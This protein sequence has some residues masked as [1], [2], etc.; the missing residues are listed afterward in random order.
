METSSDQ[1][2][3]PTDADLADSAFHEGELVGAAGSPPNPITEETDDLSVKLRAV[4]SP[5]WSWAS[6][7]SRIP[8]IYDLIVDSS[9]SLPNCRIT[10]T[11]TDADLE[12]GK[13]TVLDGQLDEGRTLIERVH[14]PLSARRMSQITERHPAMCSITVEDK[15]SGRILASHEESVDIQPRDLW[16]RHGDPFLAQAQQRASNLIESLTETDPQSSEATQIDQEIQSLQRVAGLSSRLSKSLL[17]SFVRPNHPVVAAV[18]R[19]AADLLAQST[20]DAS[21]DAYQRTPTG[22]AA[23]RAD[24][25]VSAIYR[26]LQSRS[27]VYSEPPP[28]WDYS[29]AGQRIRDHGDV[30]GGGEGTCL[31]TTVLMAAVIEQVG[32][33]P[34]LL[35]MQGHIFV[36]YWRQEPTLGNHGQSPDWYP[37][38]P[39]VPD[40][41]LV[42]DLVR[43]GF[44]GVIETTAF[45]ATKN[46]SPNDARTLAM[47]ALLKA[48]ADDDDWLELI[49][50]RAARLAGVSPL[51]AVSERP[52]GVVEIV[53]YRPGG[54]SEVTEVSREEVET[55]RRRKV[56]DHPVRYRTWKSSLF[57][58]NANNSLLNL[59]SS[60]RVQPLVLPGGDL[61]LLED[62]L[63]QDHSFQLHSGFD[64]SEVWQA[65]GFTN[66]ALLLESESSED[67]AELTDKLL[68]KNLFVQRI[69]RTRGQLAAMNYSTCL[70]ELKSMSHTAKVAREERGMNPLFLCLGLLQWSYKS[71]G[72]DKVAE[73][74]L[75][76]VPVNLTVTRR[77]SIT[78]SLDA[79]QQT[80]TNAA[81]IEWL[82][83]EHGIELE[84][85]NEP[86][87]D[88][89]GLDVDALLAAVDEAVKVH[90]LRAQI[91]AEAKLAILDLSAFRMWQDMNLHAEQ[92]LEQPL[93][94]HL[95]HTPTEQ[96]VDPALN[97]DS[98]VGTN[99]TPSSSQP[100]TGELETLETPLPADATQKQAVLWAREGRTFVLQGPP[101]T[102]K[103]Q[104][105][106]NIVSECVLSGMRVLFVAEKGTALSVVQDRLN[107]IGLKPFTLNLHHEGSSA[108]EVRAQL[109]ASMN[110]SVS[111]DPAAIDN[112]RR[113]LRNAR[114]YLGHYPKTLHERNAA[115]LSAYSARDRLLILEDGPTVEVATTLVAHRPELIE[116]LREL[117][118]DLQRWTTAAQVRPDHPWRLAGGGNADPFD[119]A[120]V[121][122]AIDDVIAGARWATDISGP[123]RDALESIWHPRQLG[124]LVAGA[125]PALPDGE[126]L[127]GILSSQW[128]STAR[129]TIDG[130]S[131]S[132]EAW[133]NHLG[134]FPPEVLELDLDTIASELQ[135]ASNSGFLGRKKRIAAALAPLTALSPSSA[136]TDPDT[137]SATLTRLREVQGTARGI[138]TSLGGVP[139]FGD[140]PPTNPFVDGALDPYRARYDTLKTASEPLRG[141][142][143]WMRTVRDLAVA[144]ALK[145]HV[146]ALTT[147]AEAWLRL[148]E[149][150]AVQDEDLNAWRADRSLVAA[151]IAYSAQWAQ[152]RQYERLMALQNWCVLSRQLEPLRQAGLN[153]T[154]VDI[155]EGRLPAD[156]A[157]DALDRGIA[158]A[159][160]AERIAA[161]GLD[162]FNSVAHDQR[163]STYREAQTELRRQLITDAPHRL[164]TARGGDGA[165]ERTGGLARELTKTT[166]KLGTRAIL[167]K[168]GTAVQELTPLILCSPSSVVDLIQPGVMEFDLV[169]FDEASQITVPEAIGALGRA[170]AAVIVGDSKQMP[171]TRRIGRGSS[172]EET[173]D[174]MADEIVED[175]ESI[176]SECE[177]ARVPTLSLNW[178]Y[179]SQDE[180]LIAFSNQ[181][182]YR[183]D[184]SS[185]PTPTLLSSE[186]GLEF[187]RVRWP[188]NNDIGM[189]LRAGAKSVDLG[190][191][192][193]AGV[194]TNHFEATAI[195]NYVVDLL[196]QSDELPSLGIV[197]FNEQQRS[198]IE[199]IFRA[200]THPQVQ[201]LMKPDE[202]TAKDKKA[203]RR[204]PLFF[205]ALEQ[206][207]GDERDIVIFSV[208]FSKQANGKI[209]TNFGPL[210]NSG[211]ERRLNVA[212]TRARRKNVIFCSFDPAEL[213]VEGATYKGPKDLKSY[214]QFAQASGS[215]ETGA[216]DTELRTPIRDRH[217][218]EIADALRAEGLHVMADVGLSDFRLDLVL[219]RPGKPDSP[220]LPVLLDGESWQKRTTV[221][222]RDVLPVEVLSEFMG[223]PTVARIWW[224]M[225]MQNRDDAIARIKAELEAA[226]AKLSA[227]ETAAAE[228]AAEMVAQKAA[229]DVDT[230]PQNPPDSRPTSGYVDGSVSHP[231]S[232]PPAAA[233]VGGESVRV[234]DSH[235]EPHPHVSVP[236]TAAVWQND[237]L[238]VDMS[239]A[240]GAKATL[241]PM[242]EGDVQAE[243]EYAVAEADIAEGSADSSAEDAEVFESL[244][245]RLT[246]PPSM[247]TDAE[248]DGA[249]AVDEAGPNSQVAWSDPTEM[250]ITVFVPASITPLGGS[251]LLDRLAEP[252]IASFVGEQV[253][254]V[255]NRE[256]PVEFGR[257]ARVVGRRFGLGRVR[258]ARTAE[259]LRLIPPD[260]QITRDELGEFA[261]PDTIDPSTWSGYRTADAELTRKLDE[262]SPIEIGNAMLDQLAKHPQVDRETLI[263]LTA[264]VFGISRLGANVR[265]RLE[266]VYDRTIQFAHND[267][268]SAAELRD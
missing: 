227:K 262:V 241:A 233:A 45:T 158:A 33:I 176:L 8:Q 97:A 55:V 65:R 61:G 83:Q 179:R 21:F 219:S 263:R 42:A 197:T 164:L 10:V 232:R 25:I 57:T 96:F 73:A 28:G 204:D 207:Q 253:L 91:K 58:L 216:D 67:R 17:A 26:A 258:A 266:T 95:V 115:G 161:G 90:G 228:Q 50:V 64:V 79:T 86:T 210:S 182:Y 85:L 174:P 163:V 244:F 264:D 156:Q 114:F 38:S 125:Q 24:A 104:T 186:T 136:L 69:G 170:R 99:I 78:M 132:A 199:E 196:D 151:T 130:C 203:P 49:D 20:G 171:P 157:A 175:Q 178:H 37:D 153:R 46:V 5:E 265:S 224:P 189:Y 3:N 152:Q 108:S 119:V 121:S 16:L 249:A 2:Q 112:A 236:Q 154:R 217:R 43:E 187:H 220:L 160:M 12:F 159:S 240:V 36:G 221:S 110:A 146:E 213:E 135:S 111:P 144:G 234:G 155:L 250:P 188:E 140:I 255:I 260:V 235:V 56:D 254:D 200:S 122:K 243:E 229:P 222:D 192:I 7:A 147:Y 214:L 231:E 54:T 223:W 13:H 118:E 84:A 190:N 149:A 169:I 116:P 48:L 89:A 150:L 51:P 80:T 134:P 248:S 19:E 256:G 107:T 15:K 31:D 268:D 172:E 23:D 184:L 53:E 109:T 129:E 226:D 47:E 212:I 35:L 183:G 230:T 251:D 143:P 145:P 124:A 34:A 18:A 30:A 225:W 242:D 59:G 162:R 247:A 166:R 193:K 106:S 127:A 22:V 27:I 206:V 101:G 103:S 62:M 102:G 202:A 211:G 41:T 173:D 123:L 208:A 94:A 165:G 191:G 215:S 14:V 205:K 92:F 70:R 1:N 168:H 87:M 209:P 60:A 113:K 68:T 77:N 93:V 98:D 245:Q 29:H 238:S 71:S 139:G 267:P 76:L 32:L 120:V 177:I 195:Y 117:F 128:P 246:T 239:P 9:A 218:D 40:G 100:D 126:V 75:I 131:Q 257:L 11:L 201:E 4:I 88:R 39:F 66:A 52:D 81:L 133:R 259:I 198:L 72:V 261:W 185:F 74:P 181:E 142:G 63:N 137:A 82:R 148:S 138:L 6:S 252:G 167:R 237:D 44:L 105:I 180:V 141:D 194:N